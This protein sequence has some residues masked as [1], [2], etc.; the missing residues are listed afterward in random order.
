MHPPS[1]CRFGQ[2]LIS[3]GQ[4]SNSELILLYGFVVDRNLFDEV[5]I[6]VSLDAS[7]PRYDEKVAFLRQGGLQVRA[8]PWQTDGT[9]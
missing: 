5:E 4:K 8:S 3:Y 7:D 2:V 6:T 1:P 9:L